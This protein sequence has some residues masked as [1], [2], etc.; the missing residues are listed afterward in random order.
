M[1]GLSAGK[2]SQVPR[3]L[4]VSRLSV[5]VPTGTAVGIAG[6]GVETRCQLLRLAL[7][8]VTPEVL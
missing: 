3:T 8:E 7:P 6:M 4:D 5:L 2:Y 1:S